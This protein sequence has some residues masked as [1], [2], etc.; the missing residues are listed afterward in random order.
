MRS[1]TAS[2]C[3]QVAELLCT[4]ADMLRAP[5]PHHGFTSSVL[6]GGKWDLTVTPVPL[7]VAEGCTQASSEC[8][9][10]SGS[11]G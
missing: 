4:P 11:L 9:H 3:F 2:V 10:M 5:D 7:L 8:A 1:R 6:V